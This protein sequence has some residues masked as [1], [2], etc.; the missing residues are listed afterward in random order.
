M[1]ATNDD[2]DDNLDDNPDDDD[3]GG[4]NGAAAADA[5]ADASADDDAAAEFDEYYAGENNVDYKGPRMTIREIGQLFDMGNST[6]HK[7][8]TEWM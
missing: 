1:V 4:Y 7:L 2:R 6:I 8:Y 5:A 3:S